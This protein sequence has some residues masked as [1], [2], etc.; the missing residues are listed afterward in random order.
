[1]TEPEVWARVQWGGA[2]EA[3]A[4]APTHISTYEGVLN[5][6]M[7]PRWVRAALC[8]RGAEP[9][10]TAWVELAAEDP[11]R[12]PWCGGKATYRRRIQG[13]PCANHEFHTGRGW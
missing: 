6:A 4:T 7:R 12:C 1:V 5:S 13:H 2:A 8:R 9:V 3:E 10:Y 11:P